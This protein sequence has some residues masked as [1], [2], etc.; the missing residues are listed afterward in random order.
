M[1]QTDTAIN[2]GNSGGPLVNLQGE[3]IGVNFAIR[4]AVQ[5]N[6]GVGFAIPVS[7]VARV[8]PALIEKGKYNWPFLGIAGGTIDAGLA[9]LVELPE[10]VT[11]VFVNQ[12]TPRGPA[13]EAGL[14]DG[15]IITAV[16]GQA[17]FSFEKLTGYLIVNTA[18]GDTIEL[19]VLRDGEPATVE[20]R[21][22][23]RP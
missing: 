15:D 17:I 18:P 21:V 23:M 2:P 8:V 11:G 6:A 19:T 4:S 9:D 20:V 16:D 7:I 10:N 3:V 1:V 14:Q 12:V 13:A 22:G 5:A